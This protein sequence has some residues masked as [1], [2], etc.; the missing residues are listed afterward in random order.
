MEKYLRDK[1]YSFNHISGKYNNIENPFL[2]RNIGRDDIIIIGKH[3]EQE[4]VIWG[5]TS[6]PDNLKFELIHLFSGIVDESRVFRNQKIFSQ[7]AYLSR[8]LH[9][10]D[11]TVRTVGIV[12]YANNDVPE[13]DLDKY[14]SFIQGGAFQ[15]VEYEHDNITD[16]FVFNI[17]EDEFIKYSGIFDPVIWSDVSDRHEIVFHY[18]LHK[19][20]YNQKFPNMY[21]DELTKYYIE[22]FKNRFEIPAFEVSLEQEAEN[23]YSVFKGTKFVIPFYEDKYKSKHF[24]KNTAV[25]ARGQG[26][27]GI[28]ENWEIAECMDMIMENTVKGLDPKYAGYKCRGSVYG[29]RRTL[30]EKYKVMQ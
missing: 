1:N 26:G 12:P 5:N 16:Y 2:I 24:V 29:Y 17:L 11:S 4:S 9:G 18:W 28:G 23:F 30:R 14:R 8:I 20:R 27:T 10:F 15:I 6:S 3:F 22:H 25:S 7:G 19:K 21:G 13:K